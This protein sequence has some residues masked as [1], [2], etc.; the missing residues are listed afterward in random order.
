MDIV[1]QLWF[2]LQGIIKVKK[3][4]NF[5]MFHL[6]FTKLKQFAVDNLNVA[7]MIAFVLNRVEKHCKTR[8][9]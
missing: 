2:C 8:G 3:R 6:L 1:S 5:L 9:P 4:N 7:Q